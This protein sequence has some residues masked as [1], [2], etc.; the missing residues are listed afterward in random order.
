MTA[1]S[2]PAAALLSQYSL[3]EVHASEIL[4]KIQT[5]QPVEYRWVT[6]K[7]DLNLNELNLSIKPDRIY[8]PNVGTVCSLISIKNSEIEGNVSACNILFKDLVDFES[9]NF[10]GDTNFGLSTFNHSAIFQFSKFYGPADFSNT[11]LTRG[12]DFMGS[13]FGTLADFR[14]TEFNDNA[15]FLGASFNGKAYFGQKSVPNS[16]EGLDIN[17]DL[18]Y[19]IMRE[20]WAEDVR[21]IS[22]IRGPKNIQCIFKGDANFCKAEFKGTAYFTGSQFIKTADFSGTKFREGANFS[23]SEFKGSNDFRG[24]VFSKFLNLTGAGFERLNI[25]W[26]YTTQLICNDG[27]TYLAL[28]KNFR[29]LEKYEVADEIYYQYRQW[30]Q[31]QKSWLDT[32]KYIDIFGFITC[33][34]GVKVSHTILSGI[35]IFVFFGIIYSIIG[36]Q[37]AL[38][39]AKLIKIIQE[40][41]LLS[42]IILL[43]APGELYPLGID[44]YKRNTETIKYWPVLERLIG[45]GLMLLLI[46]TLSRVM[47]RY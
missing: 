10:R 47:V 37:K 28:I 21:E 38:E 31:D 33:G 3:V 13:F 1:E 34:Y 7:G 45:W 17:E 32:S 41:F 40:S 11:R 39:N 16:T 22:R 42:F 19:A 15:D 9:T 26:P 27:S 18:W 12:A 29:D 46:S 2:V 6:I 20:R 25:Y 44:A 35:I 23:N 8:Q 36:L 30:R 4:Y 43:S 5:G 14:S 24:A